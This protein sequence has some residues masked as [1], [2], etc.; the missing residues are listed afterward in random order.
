MDVKTIFRLMAFFLAMFAFQ[1]C[2]DS[3]DEV[4]TEPALDVTPANI[5][6]TWMLKEWNGVELKQGTYCYIVFTRKDRTFT[7]F[8]KFDSMYARC[9]SGTYAVDKDS[10]GDYIISG[11]YDYQMGEW[12]N[13]YIV[14]ELYASGS[15]LWTAKKN[16]DDVCRY[17]R[18]DEVPQEVIKESGYK[19]E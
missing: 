6:G 1:G 3:D 13:S 11:V 9:I 8:Q 17:I 5:A 12:N 14:T 10:N 7:M 19:A 4:Y 2:S 16:P 15:M 18:C